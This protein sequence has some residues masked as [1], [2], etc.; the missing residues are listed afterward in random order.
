MNKFICVLLIVL[1][2]DFLHHVSVPMEIVK[3]LIK[4]LEDLLAG[5][6]NRE[7]QVLRKLIND[8][9]FKGSNFRKAAKTILRGDTYKMTQITGEENVELSE[10]LPLNQADL[11]I[12]IK[13][14]FGNFWKRLNDE[15]DKLR[16]P[17]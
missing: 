14:G 1:G 4:E 7:H 16:G 11:L 2:E 3:E 5:S 12:R 13:L 17:L 15:E 10:Y 6:G 8:E 9:V